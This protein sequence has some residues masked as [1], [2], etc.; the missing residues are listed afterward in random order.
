M[1]RFSLFVLALVAMLAASV[2]WSSPPVPTDS[3][4][5]MEPVSISDTDSIVVIVA[6]TVTVS[7]VRPSVVQPHSSLGDASRSC[8]RSS[9]SGFPLLSR[10]AEE[11][12]TGMVSGVESSMLPEPV[13]AFGDLRSRDRLHADRMAPRYRKWA[14]AFRDVIPHRRCPYRPSILPTLPST[15][16]VVTGDA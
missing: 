9:A 15:A 3:G 1:N 12:P 13:L 6:E 7:W 14:H 2:A 5:I 10:S 11:P 16:T 4:A 8:S